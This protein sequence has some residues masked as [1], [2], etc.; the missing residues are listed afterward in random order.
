M[1][2]LNIFY[3]LYALF[4]NERVYKWTTGV[5]LGGH[6]NWQLSLLLLLALLIELPAIWII[7]RDMRYRGVK[8]NENG[9]SFIVVLFAWVFHVGI[10]GIILIDLIASLGFSFESSLG[11]LTIVFLIIRE[12]GLLFMVV[13]Y[14][15]ISAR[16][17]NPRIKLLAEFGLIYVTGIVYTK[18]IYPW[19]A[20]TPSLPV[21][22][23]TT[24]PPINPPDINFLYVLYLLFSQFIVLFVVFLAFCVVYIPYRFVHFIR[25]LFTVKNRRDWIEFILSLITAYI[26]LIIV[27]A[28]IKIIKILSAIRI[29]R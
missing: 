2:G 10:S 1:W 27:P 5:E 3:A 16:P 22:E 7:L 25:I 28:L 29:Q 18:T 13:M 24:P 14:K 9:G 26:S 4:L 19:V 17:I 8:S 21:Y 20:A 23:I 11:Y 15:D 6:K 12:L